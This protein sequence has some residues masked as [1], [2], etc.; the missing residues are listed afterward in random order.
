MREHRLLKR[1][2]KR[3][4]FILCLCSVFWVLGSAVICSV[5][6]AGPSADKRFV[7]YVY[8]M[9]I[10]AG[11]AVLKYKNTPE[12]IIIQTQATSASI[13]SV[14]YKVDDF[15]QSLLY[16]D[17]YPKTFILKVREGFHRRHKIT[18]FEP[19][20]PGKPQKVIF[21]NVLDEDVQEFNLEEPAYDPLSAFYAITKTGVKIGETSYINVFDNKK[22]WRTEIQVLKKE[23][24]R[25]LAGEFDTI[26]VKPLLESEGIF[27]KTGEMHIWLTDDDR[28]IPV[29]FTSKAIIGKFTAILAKGDID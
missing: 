14:F 18:N 1:L 23:K 19:R 6:E 24:I 17:G 8:W 12:G 27:I 5:V 11:K 9:G 20:V 15:A 16:P 26:L 21:N 2:S 13:I 4:S 29:R 22:F 28:R 7:Y 25:V 3:V 10:R